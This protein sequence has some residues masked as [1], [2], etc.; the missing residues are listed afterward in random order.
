MVLCSRMVFR[1]DL[2]ELILM[3]SVDV[4]LERT[5]VETDEAS[6]LRLIKYCIL[7][8]RGSWSEEEKFQDHQRLHSKFKLSG[9]AR[10]FCCSMF[11]ILSASFLNAIAAE[12]TSKACQMMDYQYNYTPCSG[13]LFASISRNSACSNFFYRNKSSAII[14]STAV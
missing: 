10:L 4:D 12:N 2:L 11:E 8:C 3:A 5:A 1:R 13:Y 9:F 14:S 7:N 6:L